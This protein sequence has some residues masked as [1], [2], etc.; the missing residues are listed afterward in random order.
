MEHLFIALRPWWTICVR[1]SAR[2]G[3]G[4]V[5]RLAGQHDSQTQLWWTFFFGVSPEVD[6]LQSI[7]LDTGRFER[8]NPMDMCTYHTWPA[9]AGCWLRHVENRRLYWCRRWT[10]WTPQLSATDLLPTIGWRLRTKLCPLQGT[11]ILISVD[12]LSVLI[13]VIDI[14]SKRLW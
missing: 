8:V 9:T 13:D 5:V 14:T 12:F 6:R 10:V 1:Y 3:L 11:H 2:D 7:T 4:G